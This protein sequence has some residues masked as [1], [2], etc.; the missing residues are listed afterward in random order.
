[1]AI[2]SVVATLE[3]STTELTETDS[4]Y[5]GELTA[6]DESGEY[7]VSISAYDD[8]GN[9][10]VFNDTIVE[11]TLWKEPKTNWLPTDRFNFVDYNRIKNNLVHLHEKA[12]Q[13]WKSFSMEDMGED[14]LSYEAMWDFERFNQFERNLDVINQNIFTKDYGYQQVFV[15]NGK[16]ITYD[17]LNRIES[18]ILS[19]KI[20]LDNQE[21]GLRRLMIRLG[22]WKGVKV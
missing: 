21:A 1:M 20:I 6:P 17:E 18:A 12:N 3:D 15:G 19:M 13:L 10:A 14:I 9:I 11:V 7:V 4:G 5:S 2:E 16:F 8:A 22:N